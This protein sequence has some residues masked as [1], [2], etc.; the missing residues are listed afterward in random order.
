M[1]VT[2][3]EGCNRN[4]VQVISTRNIGVF[5]QHGIVRAWQQYATI[6]T[7]IESNPEHHPFPPIHFSE[8]L[9]LGLKSCEFVQPESSNELP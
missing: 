8:G 4:S 6:S 3:E 9:Q 1:T 2:L 7:L 5:E